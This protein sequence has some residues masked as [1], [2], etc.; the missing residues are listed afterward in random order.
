M[1]LLGLRS[2]VF[3]EVAAAGG[4]SFFVEIA[5]L[6]T[7]ALDLTGATIATSN[8]DLGSFVFP[9][10]NLNPGELVVLTQNQLG[11]RPQDTDRLLL[12]S[13]DG[14]TILDGQRVT[15]RLRGRAEQNAADWLYPLTPTPGSQNL[16]EF[17]SEIVIN[18][19]MYHASPQLG[20]LERAASYERTSLV[21]MTWDQWKYN[22]SGEKLLSGWATQDYAV[23]D[24]T[25]FQ[26]KTPM[27]TSD[28]ALP[29]PI[30]TEFPPP[31]QN[32][33]PFTTFYFQ[34]DFDI[35][36]DLWG[37]IDVLELSHLIDDGAIFYLNGQEI[38][39]F[40]LPEGDVGPDTV[41]STTVN[42]AGGVG[43]I[44]VPP[45][46]L[47]V[48]R[49]TLSAELHLRTRFDTDVVF[50][51]RLAYGIQ[52]AD[53][54][55]G[56]VYEERDEAEWIE[57]Y[58]RSAHPVDL[59]GWRLAE[60]IEFAIPAGTQLGPDQYLVIAK[61][62][63][64]FRGNY[65][66]V[67][68]LGSFGG[69]LSDHD[70]R[71][72]LVDASGNPA[73]DVHYYEGG[74]WSS[75]ADGGGSSLELLNPLADNGLGS[76][77]GA[78][79]ESDGSEWVSYAF[80]DVSQRDVFAQGPLYH[81]LLFGLFSEGEF[82]IDDVEV[83]EDPGGEAISMIQN[84]TFESDTV[85]Q[86][87]A[88][89][90]LIGNHSGQ[91]VTDPND[92]ENQVLH[93]V[94]T[95]GQQFVHDHAETTFANGLGIQDGAE[96]RISFRVKWISGSSQLHSRLWFNRVPNTMHLHVPSQ[97]GTPGR[98]NRGF[99]ANLGPALTRLEHTPT[100][101][102][103]TEAVQVSVAAA[104][105]NG[106]AAVGLWYRRDGET[107]NELAMTDSGGGVYSASI[108]PQPVGTVVQFYV[109]ATD[110]VGVSTMF[111]AAGPLSRAL[112][113]VEDGIGPVTAIDRI[114]LVVMASEVTDLFE[115]TQ[116]MSNRFLPMTLVYN[117]EPYY[118]VSVRLV[119]SRFTRPDSGYNVQL[120]PEK[121]LYGVHDSIRLDINGIAEIIV[122]QML[123]RAG[124]SK[125]SNYDDLAYL[126]SPFS[127]HNGE[128][129]LQLAR[130]ENLYFEEQFDNGGEGTKFR[131]DDVT[132]PSDP[133]GGLEGLK[134][135]TEVKSNGDIGINAEF[136]SRQGGNPE[137]YRA[138][139]LIRNNREKDDFASIARLAQS[140][141]F[142][143][144][145]L[146]EATNA[147]M[148]VDLWMRHY[149]HQ[150]FFGN[151]DSYGARRPKNLRIF[152]RPGDE[153]A[154][155]LM[156]DC[157]SCS[158]TGGLMEESTTSRL[159]EIRSIPHNLRLYWGHLLD[160][161][162]RSFNESYVARWAEH[163]GTL[164]NGRAGGTLT[165]A[166]AASRTRDQA[167]NVLNTVE[168][169]IPKVDFQITTN[170]GQPIRVDQRTVTLEGTGWVD[171]RQIRLAGSARA[172]DA[173]WP[174][175]ST[176][177]IA[178]PLVEGENEI[179]LEAVDFRGDVMATQSIRVSSTVVDPI[180][181][182]LRITELNFSPAQPT[183]AEIN[184]G[185]VDGDDFE[186]IE[187]FNA[188]AAEPLN[189]A[190]LAFAGGVEFDFPDRQLLP[191]EYAVVVED[192]Q[193]F[194]YRYGPEITILGQWSGGL[195][196]GGE[197]LV[198]IDRAGNEVFDFEFGD[199]DP[200]PERADGQGAT[201][202][203]RDVMFTLPGQMGNADF[204]RGSTE[205]GG[206]PGRPGIGSL[207]VV[208]N[209]VIANPDKR[210]VLFDS[211]EL[212][213]TTDRPI[214][215]GGWYLSD[216]ANRLLKY[217]IPANVVIP[218]GGYLV[219]SENDFNPSP[220]DPGPDDFA[221]G[222]SGDDVWLVIPPADGEVLWFVDDV[223]FGATPSG[224]SMGRVPDGFGRLVPLVETTFG[225]PNANPRFG[226]V[227]ISELNYAPSQPAAADLAIDPTLTAA[228]LE[229]LEL[230]NSGEEPE[231]LTDWR[232]RGGVAFDFP[233]GTILNAAET[234][235]IVSFDPQAA[236][237]VN[238]LAAFREHFQIEAAV[239]IV[240]DY[241]G[242]LADRGKRIQLQRAAGAEGSELHWWEDELLYDIAPP[243]PELDGKGQ[244]L[245]RTAT[246]AY[247]NDPQSWVTAVASPGRV[248]VL[249]TGDFNGDGVVDAVDV[250]ELSAGVRRQ[251]LRFD[252]DGSGSTTQTDLAWM[253][254][255]VL[256]TTF[257]D[258]NLDGTFDSEDLVLV[259]QR[260]EY[261][262]G[263]EG[264]SGWE[265][266]DWDGDGDFTS[267]DFVAAFQ[268]GGYRAAAIAP[269]WWETRLDAHDPFFADLD[270]AFANWPDNLE[271]DGS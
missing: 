160:L 110:G 167:A 43:P 185:F 206:S 139:L 48:G 258:V 220:D 204:W 182:S 76:S 148:D 141:Y 267:S 163:Y 80:Q 234:L 197:S 269:A 230:S 188:N 27:G 112:Y 31:R 17:H 255:A 123:N 268:D 162:D 251:D 226:P 227:V 241:A 87:P 47:Q 247:G 140:L 205:L 59:S 195:A 113:Q 50:G 248:D 138:H 129:I 11:F 244:S 40:N 105:P 66:D 183:Q 19:I 61:N 207:G 232:L 176:W 172:L 153:L 111:P 132:V 242:R 74:T 84:G 126:V 192:V 49:N 130:Y 124:G 46:L 228:D 159:D 135:G 233:A 214:D 144:R 186:F 55:P 200:W 22:A 94:A 102:L 109:E 201:L 64:V 254:H 12:F 82:L 8:N 252:L 114:R 54:I 70:D 164:A 259:F 127:R 235:L 175:A 121:P 34:T 16:F 57:L 211:V 266:G 165:F 26:G 208:I 38:E 73:D 157:D 136:V 90:R 108:P 215:I 239:P 23:D 171:I 236:A 238:R 36:A 150:T 134:L 99:E 222:S 174:A 178:L 92:S 63:D 9:S 245:T 39:R 219:F 180:F 88:K 137:F 45:E 191:G 98:R 184:H 194:T 119:G 95:G 4:D 125:A 20:A 56:Q 199:N 237:N 257:G 28:T 221:F 154:V 149:A 29:L 6:S 83:V 229:F 116:R 51:A 69:S 62:V 77:W 91:V 179:L 30:G 67:P 142:E 85:G 35:T 212:H 79:D 131:M 225:T 231:D 100:T 107:W 120:S 41:A 218:A 13:A 203:L 104:D 158:L 151:G 96:Y 189:L 152:I 14:E 202:E 261:E 181:E 270:A 72:L 240:G 89:W 166:N 260:G 117:D 32:A 243:W 262:D 71:I 249:T 250:N 103:P 168:S 128:M 5:N 210:V 115:P 256:G 2:L 44:D 169:V 60:A 217:R 190:G 68:V 21:T 37:Q 53:P 1:R 3:N 25:W 101:P 263:I 93:V 81:E 86:P 118:N 133:V 213:N 173:Y 193:A 147:T 122:K 177:R 271:L 18:E 209:E 224:E 265:D 15:G 187:V 216:S 145:E 33:P 78:S 10:S 264:N 170:A 246:A 143:G 161:V 7:A 52:T 75:V 58:N 97:T 42:V 155:P 156:W 223:H 24:I 65:P 146:F 196:N 198:L 253:I 106:V